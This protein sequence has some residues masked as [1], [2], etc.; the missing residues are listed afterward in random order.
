MGEASPGHAIN[1]TGKI[2][3]ISLVFGGYDPDHTKLY[4]SR[5]LQMS[6]NGALKQVKVARNGFARNFMLKEDLFEERVLVSCM[7][8]KPNGPAFRLE[9]NPSKLGPESTAT[10]L[11]IV[12]SDILEGGTSELYERA[13]VTRFDVAFDLFGFSLS[14]AHFW[15]NETSSSQTYNAVGMRT[16]TLVFNQSKRRQ[17]VVYDKA[18]ERTSKGIQ[19]K[20]SPWTR[21][22][23]RKRNAGQLA[24][25][26][27]TK[28]PFLDFHVSCRKKPADI[29]EATWVLINAASGP[30]MLQAVLGQLPMSKRALVKNILKKH[31]LEGW[32]A[33]KLWKEWPTIVNESG[34]L[35]PVQ[36]QA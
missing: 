20:V 16:E 9:F 28:C 7:S 1:C 29:S 31:P 36:A 15:A 10:V 26:K 19:P 2:D 8:T 30:M 18:A 13:R 33:A 35:A 23:V 5:I 32:N 14:Q 22:E 3:N 4:L 34:L 24:A 11:S 25:L 21:I 12:A 6:S 17:V 27:S